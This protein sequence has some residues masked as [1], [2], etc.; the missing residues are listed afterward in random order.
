M[1]RRVAAGRLGKDGIGTTKSIKN[2]KKIAM[3]FCRVAS[4]T[5]IQLIAFP[6]F[7]FPIPERPACQ[8]V[9][10]DGGK[11]PHLPIFLFEALGEWLVC[12][13][14]GLEDEKRRNRNFIKSI[15]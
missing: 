13:I 3:S 5:A 1:N 14:F 8:Q 6:P 10:Q 12:K 9:G 2:T 15:D 11:D 4:Q 7:P